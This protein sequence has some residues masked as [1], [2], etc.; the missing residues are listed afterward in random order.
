MLECQGSQALP[1]NDIWKWTKECLPLR[2]SY[3][4]GMLRQHK[5]CTGVFDKCVKIILTMKCIL[6]YGNILQ[7]AL[8]TERVWREEWRGNLLFTVFAC[9][10]GKER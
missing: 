9:Q 5:T 4:Y 8:L 2:L 1:S 7:V 6:C 10:L 3:A